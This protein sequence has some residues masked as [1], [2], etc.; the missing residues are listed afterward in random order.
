MQDTLFQLF[1]KKFYIYLLRWE[2]K[3]K[4]TLVVQN[5]V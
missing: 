5:F 3:F 1:K 4:M 2:M